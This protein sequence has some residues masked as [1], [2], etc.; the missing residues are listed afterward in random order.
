MYTLEFNALCILKHY[1][2]NLDG[3]DLDDASTWSEVFGRRECLNASV[4]TST[5][6]EGFSAN[7]PRHSRRGT[8]LK[9]D[10]YVRGLR[11]DGSWSSEN[12]TRRSR[13]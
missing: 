6:I 4:Q 2:L 9:I 7:E 11:L 1:I 3:M 12:G 5:D 13:R 10:R 8:R